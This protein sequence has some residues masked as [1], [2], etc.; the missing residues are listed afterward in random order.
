MSRATFKH[1]SSQRAVLLFRM[2]P[3]FGTLCLGLALLSSAMCVVTT[4]FAYRVDEPRRSRFLEAGG[5]AS[6][7]TFG[8]LCL[9]ALTLLYLFLN[10]D[11]SVLYVATQSRLA[12][13]TLFKI[14]AVWSGMQGSILMWAWILALYGVAL[15]RVGRKTLAGSSVWRVHSTALAVLA[16][17]NCFFIG[18]NAFVSNPFPPVP[19]AIPADGR[20]IE[21]LL[22]NVWMQIHPPTLYFGYVGCSVPW[23]LAAAGLIHRKFD[24]EWVLLVR[25]WGLLT[26]IILTVGIIMGGAWAYETLGWGG[27]WAWDPVENASLLPWLTSTAFLHSIMI[28]ARRGTLKSWNITLVTLSF[29]LSVFGTAMTH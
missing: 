14:S 12:Q 9:A 25:R 4:A 6:R 21:P 24:N 16:G 29:L 7:A 23:A 17:V 15:G 19:G 8:L 10:D 5:R 26:W 28:Q 18:L 13:P 20:G 22:Q 1:R 27:Y 3:S 11:F 2:I